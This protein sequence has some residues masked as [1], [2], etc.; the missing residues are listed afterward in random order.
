MKRWSVIG[1]TMSWI[2]SPKARRVGGL[3][4]GFLS[5]LS[6][7]RSSLTSCVRF[8]RAYADFCLCSG[9]TACNCGC[10]SVG[11]APRC[12][13]GCRGFESHH[14]LS[15]DHVPGT[16]FRGVEVVFARVPGRARGSRPGRLWHTEDSIMLE[17]VA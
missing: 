11:R 15:C 9:S 8:A 12:Q 4:V 2:E 10:S 13:R 3:A 7:V 1:M 16:F 5:P 17:T 14:P 6:G